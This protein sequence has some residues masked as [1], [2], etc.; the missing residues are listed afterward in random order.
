MEKTGIMK[1][2]FVDNAGWFIVMV[3]IYGNTFGV[4][5]SYITASLASFRPMLHVMIGRLTGFPLSIIGAIVM[6]D[7]PPHGYAISLIVLA[8][9]SAW[10]GGK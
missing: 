7:M 10:L 8:L 2:P 4:G 5:G 1:K 9:R 3:V 6:W